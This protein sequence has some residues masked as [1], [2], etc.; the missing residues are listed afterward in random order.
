MKIT[1]AKMKVQKGGEDNEGKDL[2]PTC[3]KK[4]KENIKKLW[5]KL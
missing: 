1:N 5:T 3:D 4:N 2:E